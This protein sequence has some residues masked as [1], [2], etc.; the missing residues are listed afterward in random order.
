MYETIKYETDA[1]E[2]TLTQNSLI[3]NLILYEQMQYKA[4]LLYDNTQL[5]M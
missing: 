3:K 1:F 5:D 4:I 2:P